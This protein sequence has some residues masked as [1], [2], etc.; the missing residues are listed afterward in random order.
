MLS[1]LILCW[2]LLE[3]PLLYIIYCF[4]NIT[5]MCYE[6]CDISNCENAFH[7]RVKNYVFFFCFDRIYA[8]GVLHLYSV[9][10]LNI[11]K[12]YTIAQ[13]IYLYNVTITFYYSTI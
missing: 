12:L 1:N 13:F 11:T 6:K 8:V 9:C 2:F 5:F 4:S 10:I 3:Y 7:S